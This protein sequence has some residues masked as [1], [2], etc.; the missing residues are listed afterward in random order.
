MARLRLFKEDQNLP[1]KQ[2]LNLVA[3]ASK[4]GLFFVGTT[5]GFNGKEHFF[6]VNINSQL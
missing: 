2:S 3:S 5:S 6:S 1:V 4:F